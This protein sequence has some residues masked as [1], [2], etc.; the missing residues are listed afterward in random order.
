MPASTKIGF[1]KQFIPVLGSIIEKGYEGHELQEGE[2]DFC[3]TLFEDNRGNAG[4][5]LLAQVCTI[6]H[7]G[8][9][10]R[11]KIKI[12]DLVAL[13]GNLNVDDDD[14]EETDQN[15]IEE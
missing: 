1:L 13:T 15:K 2:I 4:S 11:S 8:N 9:V 14:A 10:V 6:D 5:R 12:Y 7:H 3:T